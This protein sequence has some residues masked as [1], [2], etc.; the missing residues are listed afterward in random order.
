MARLRKFRAKKMASN[1][2]AGFQGTEGTQT[3]LEAMRQEV[4]VRVG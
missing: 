4:E 1:A 3:G 2:G